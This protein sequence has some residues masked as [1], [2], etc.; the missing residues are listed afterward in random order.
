MR[1]W[2]PARSRA[3]RRRAAV[4]AHLLARE[5][6]ERELL[7]AA[8]MGATF[9]AL[10]EAAYPARLAEIDDAPPLLAVRG[11]AVLNRG[12]L[13]MV[14]ARNASAAGLKITERLAR[15][16]GA[17]GFGVVSGLARG[18]DAAAHRATLETGT[19]AVLAGG[20]ARRSI[21]PSTSISSTR[22][23]SEGAAV[24]EMPFGWEP[25]GR[26][27]PRRN[28]L[29]SGLEP[30]RDR[31]RGGAEIRLADH[32]AARAASRAARCLRCRAL[33]LDPR[34]DGS[35]GAAQAGRDAGHRSR[36][37]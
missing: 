15:D 6:A 35:N 28:R 11:N 14:G 19:V 29:I 21:R 37:T 25:R 4:Q 7:A 13:A 18:I 12:L 30:R 16:L 27:F 3:A 5:D 17:A 32:G 36:T 26:D 33:P 22:S 10:G 23:S 1:R 24:S 34:A 31:G 20:H 2:R 8:R 9:V